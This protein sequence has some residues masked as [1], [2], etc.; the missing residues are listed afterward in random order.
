MSS[1][2][3]KGMERNGDYKVIELRHLFLAKEEPAAPVEQ[4]TP[5]VDPEETAARI[6]AEAEEKAEAIIAGAR[7]AAREIREKATQEA[8][9][10]ARRVK[11]EAW[12]EPIQKA[13][14]RPWPGP[15]P[16]LPQLGI[17][18]DWC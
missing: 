18:P 12:E 5:E 16:T 4:E 10:E 6:I 3:I 11:Q 13:E 8:M 9:E 7:E 2:I 1:R 17:R 14:E 15:R